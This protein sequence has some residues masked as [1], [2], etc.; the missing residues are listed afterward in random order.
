[1]FRA[2][3]SSIDSAVTDGPDLRKP[4]NSH[5]IR[6]LFPQGHVPRFFVRG[7]ERISLRVVHESGALARDTFHFSTAE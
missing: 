4:G 3:V 1:M 5:S 6:M 7:D 2:P